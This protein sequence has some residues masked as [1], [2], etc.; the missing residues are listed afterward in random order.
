[1]GSELVEQASGHSDQ[2]Y[3]GW[4]SL[5]CRLGSM[6]QRHPEIGCHLAGVEVGVL[7]GVVGA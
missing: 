1:M 2:R 6:T 3:L 4:E 7:D 5:A